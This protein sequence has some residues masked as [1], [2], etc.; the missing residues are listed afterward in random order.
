MP[1]YSPIYHKKETKEKIAS[2]LHK[3]KGNA[4]AIANELGW[5]PRLVRRIINKYDDL[6]WVRDEIKRYEKLR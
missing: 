5:P 6:Q 4:T 1:R 3:H 2:L